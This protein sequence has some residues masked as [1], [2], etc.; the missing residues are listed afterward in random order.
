MSSI[1]T[2]CKELV[3]YAPVSRKLT[4]IGREQDGGYVCVELLSD[5]L[6]SYGVGDDISFELD[7]HEKNSCIGDVFLYDH[8]VDKL[9]DAAPAQF[10]FFK[11]A[12]GPQ[13]LESHL[14]EHGLP[15]F[16]KTL[17]MDVE[18]SEWEAFYATP[19]K[20]LGEFSQIICELHIVPVLFSKTDQ[21]PY[22]TR[23]FASTYDKINDLMF[24][25]Y[26][27]VL[28]H[29][30][31]THT[32]VHLHPNNSLPCIEI[33]GF[34]IPQLLE[35]TFLHSKLTKEF[36]P[37]KGVLPVDGL[38]FPNKPWKPEIENFYPFKRVL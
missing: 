5:Q 28:C 18:W 14:D 4:R 33:D 30:K 25:M 38:D 22:F 34:K 29:L 1:E 24:D 6:F 37:F 26:T 2:F 31:Q 15:G 20:T 21:T 16:S 17:K 36:I 3:V 27:T 10:H 12:L 11:E 8:T 23:F 19:S 9:P 13:S 7:F 35:A 32:L